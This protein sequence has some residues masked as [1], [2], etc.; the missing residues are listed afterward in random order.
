MELALESEAAG[1]FAGRY[2]TSVRAADAYRKE[3]LPQ[4]E[5]AHR[6]Y[7]A[8]Y[9]E[10]AAAYPPVMA[11]DRRAKPCSSCRAITA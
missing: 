6:L 7:L 10:M 9:K 2:L 4:A 8:R 1:E 11:K 5:E 3:I